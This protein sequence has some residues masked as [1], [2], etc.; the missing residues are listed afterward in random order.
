MV[1]TSESIQLSP[2]CSANYL[3]CTHS[4]PHIFTHICFHQP[5]LLAEIAFHLSSLSPLHILTKTPYRHTPLLTLFSDHH[6]NCFKITHFMQ[7]VY[8]PNGFQ[9]FAIFIQIGGNDF[10]IFW[11]VNF[12]IKSGL[13]PGIRKS[14]ST[15]KN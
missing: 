7:H 11:L 12:S 6:A 15:N 13:W 3:I 1:Q 9:Q 4:V 10:W 14:I 8:H 5:C 2:D